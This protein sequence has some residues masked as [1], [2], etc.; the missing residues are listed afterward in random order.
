MNATQSANATNQEFHQYVIGVVIALLT[1]FFLRGIIVASCLY[2][3]FRYYLPNGD[4]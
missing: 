1:Y 4:V 3:Y 2:F